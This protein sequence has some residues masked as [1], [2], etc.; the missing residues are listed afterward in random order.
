MRPSP[1]KPSIEF[2]NRGKGLHRVGVCN[3]R[4]T[5]LPIQ[6]ETVAAG[7]RLG[8]FGIPGYLA[9]IARSQWSHPLCEKRAPADG[10]YANAAAQPLHLACAGRL[11]F[12]AL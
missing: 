5:V 2:L 1:T 3:Q 9:I 8:P 10:R 4:R 7:L 6:I 12:S 11:L